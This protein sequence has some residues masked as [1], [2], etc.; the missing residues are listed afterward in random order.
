MNDQKGM[1][2]V[3][4]MVAVV[5]ISLALITMMDMFDLGLNTTLKAEMETKAVELAQ[6]KIEEAKDLINHSLPAETS[7]TSF[8]EPENAGYEY[9]IKEISVDG[10]KEIKVVVYYDTNK[11]VV[12]VTRLGVRQ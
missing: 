5:I 8:P 11:S 6:E 10:V 1:T 7:R 9:E 4:L 3:E 2:L 12:L